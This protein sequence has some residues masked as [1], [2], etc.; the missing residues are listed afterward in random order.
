MFKTPTISNLKWREI[1]NLLVGGLGAVIEEGRDSRVR[2]ALN[3][4]FSIVHKM[5]FHE[6]HPIC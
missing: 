3:D 2:V 6:P 5:T 4:R 1:E